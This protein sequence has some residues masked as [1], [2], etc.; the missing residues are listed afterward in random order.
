VRSQWG[1]Y[2]LPRCITIWWL[3]PPYHTSRDP[4]SSKSS[5]MSR[6]QDQNPPWRPRPQAGNMNEKKRHGH[7]AEDSSISKEIWWIIIW[8]V[9]YIY[10][11]Y[12]YIH[13][14]YI[15]I[16]I[17]ICDMYIYTWYIYIWYIYRIDRCIHRK[18]K[19]HMMNSFWWQ[20]GR[21]SSEMVDLPASMFDCLRVRQ[22][23]HG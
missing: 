6:I 12:I 1:R 15:H 9:I 10:M 19:E 22:I 7:I 23:N 17:Y 13:D 3:N 20:R 5:L 2:N 4:T 18:F 16:Y 21:K 8:Y 14:I 11:L